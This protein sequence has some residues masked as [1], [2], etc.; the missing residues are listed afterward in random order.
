LLQYFLKPFAEPEFFSFTFSNEDVKL[1]PVY[2]F[3]G[4]IFD[5]PT[6][7][8][9]NSINV[10]KYLYELSTHPQIKSGDLFVVHFSDVVIEDELVDMVGVFKSE[11]LAEL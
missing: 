6:S 9:I 10:A 3:A 7:F 2:N 4:Q 1:N 8:H 5:A 11:N